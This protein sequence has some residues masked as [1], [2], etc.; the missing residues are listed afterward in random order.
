MR[1]VVFYFFLFS[2]GTTAQERPIFERFDEGLAA[3]YKQKYRE[4]EKSSASEMEVLEQK[5]KL[6]TAYKEYDDLMEAL[7]DKLAITETAELRYYLGGINGIKALSVYRL[8]ALPYVRS[9]LYNFK[10][11]IALDPTYTP[12]IEAY[13]ESLCLVPSI[14]GGDVEKAIQ[15]SDKLMQLNK[16]EGYFSKGFISKSLGDEA[17]AV[18]AY[19]QGFMA[20]EALDFCQ[21]D[22]EAFFKDKSLNFSFKIAEA[23]TRFGIYPQLGLCA[24][25]YFIAHKSDAYNIP[26]EWAYFRKAQLHLLLNDKIAAEG[27]IENAL[28]IQP[29]FDK[30]Q[31]LKQA[32]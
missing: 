30:A 19:S 24:I 20:L 32:L 9:M 13:I 1:W 26:F 10:Q 28:A 27:A 7:E 5:I 21:S 14:I 23:S 16:V 12:A 29:D 17:A 18:S 31:A 2:L 25:D 8:F 3:E 11:A 6:S 22:Q 4:L 15:L